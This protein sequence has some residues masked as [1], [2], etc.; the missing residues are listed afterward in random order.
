MKTANPPTFASRSLDL[1]TPRK[2]SE[3]VLYLKSEQ[4]LAKRK[5]EC[6]CFECLQNS[7][8]SDSPRRKLGEFFL[9]CAFVSHLF[10]PK[11]ILENGIESGKF[12]FSKNS[13]AFVSFL[14]QMG[15]IRTDKVY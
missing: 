14:T 3:T 10:C 8:D 5:S 1:L 12:D 11:A 7:E 2:A 15:G 9:C 6:S 4:D 13:S